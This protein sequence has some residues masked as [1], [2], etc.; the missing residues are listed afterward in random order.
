MAKVSHPNVVAVH[1]VGIDGACVFVAMEF[2]AGGTLAVWLREAER[3]WMAVLGKFI[4]AGRGL[5]AAHSAG[6]V[7]RDFKPDNVLVGP[8]ERVVVTDFGLARATTG[9]EVT[10]RRS[11][12]AGET[13]GSAEALAGTPAYMAP[14]QHFGEPVGPLSDLFSFCVALY[15][16]LYGYRPFDA[17]SWE[18]IRAKIKAGVVPPP[19]VDS[20]VPRRIFRVLVRGLSLDPGARWPSMEALVETLERDPV[21]SRLRGLGLAG[22]VGATAALSYTVAVSQ[23]GERS[24]C[25]GAGAEVAAVWGPEARVAVERAFVATGAPFAGA[26]WQRVAGRLDGYAGAW[27]ASASEACEANAAGRESDRLF[28]LRRSCLERRRAHLGALVAAL[29]EAD[30]EAVE[31][32]VQ[33]VAGLPRV[34][35][36]GDVERLMAAVP[37]PEDP[38]EAAAVE[39]EEGE[40]A[41]A[42]VLEAIGHYDAGLQVVGGVTARAE[43]MGYAPLEAEAALVRGVLEAAMAEPEAA[44][45]S[46]EAALRLGIENDQHDVA[47]EAAAR[48][49]F[50]VGEGLGRHG[51]ALAEGPYAA[52]LVARA[53]EVR[54]AALLQNNLGTV[55]DLKGEDVAAKVSY[56]RAITLLTE[57]GEEGDPLLAVAHFNLGAMYYDQGAVERA[58][59]HYREAE[60]R[61]VEVL[62]ESHPY[63]AHAL[64]GLG[65]A[66]LAMG[67]VVAAESSFGGALATL[68]AS[69][70]RDHF[71]VW[72]ALAGIGRV[73]LRRGDREAARAEF[74][75][76]VALG[77]RE[78]RPSSAVG[79]ALEGLGELA[80]GS[81]DVAAARGFYERAA[82]AF[83][84]AL[85]EGSARVIQA[86]GRAAALCEP[87]A[88]SVG[89]A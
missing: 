32:A 58:A 11:V 65:E 50:V 24:R 76:V 17:L 42:R 85:G 18:G 57:A 73:H 47:A 70:G 67:D 12:G 15:E 49:V 72:Q 38:V 53:G 27:A 74:A 19:P 10:R 4:L 28:D 8:G 34:E 78:G 9:A 79:D 48:R 29:R 69:F 23:L 20:P 66:A 40:L 39:R 56:E 55:E 30:R 83:E 81:G 5:A 2:V 68:E 80:E 31:N 88:G 3:D 61:M 82:A 54:L 87:A 25:V 21:R 77:E 75:R 86:R 22:L 89:G 46:L 63:V 71:F 84:A 51:E 45:R 41:R 44:A 13:G 35:S 59:G 16:G 52:A 37:L 33:A 62:G 14:E 7:H 26:V 36:C 64:T 6:I 1:D 43:E 60:R